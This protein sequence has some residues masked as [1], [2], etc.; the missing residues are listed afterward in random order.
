MYL[1]LGGINTWLSKEC[2]E[3]EKLDKEIIVYK[4]V[5]LPVEKG[6][7]LGECNYYLDDVLLESVPLVAQDGASFWTLPQI[8]KIIFT[9]FLSFSWQTSWNSLDLVI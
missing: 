4:D 8:M 1:D 6:Q 9:E 3:N 7:K 2:Y 5:K